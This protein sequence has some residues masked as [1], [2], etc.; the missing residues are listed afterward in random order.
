MPDKISVLVGGPAGTGIMTTGPTLSRAFSRGGLHVYVNIEYPSLIRGGHNS[1]QIC[2]GTSPVHSHFEYIDFLLA[3][4]SLT[5]EEH[6]EELVPGANIVCDAK[7]CRTEEITRGYDVNI[8]SMPIDEIAVESGG[9]EVMRNMVALGATVALIGYNFDCLVDAI[10]YTFRARPKIADQNVITAKAGY[11]YINEHH[12]NYIKP[13]IQSIGGPKRIS[14]SGNEAIA[15]GAIKAGMKWYSAYPMTPSTSVLHYLMSHERAFDLVIKQPEDEI[16][17]IMMAIG[18]AF[19]GVR[20]G[21]GTSGGGFCL[22]TEGLGLAGMIEV[23]LVIVEAQRG[24]PST[25]LPTRQE[26]A[27][28]GFLVTASQGEFPRIIIA[29]GDVDECFYETFNAFNLA[30]RYQVPVFVLTDKYLSENFQTTEPFKTEGLKIN[31]GQLLSEEEI[32]SITEFKRFAFTESGISPRSIPGQSKGIHR[33]TGNEH[34]ESGHISDDADNRK[35]M[36]EKRV[37]RKFKTIQKDIPGP[38]Q[39]GPETAPLTLVCW[40]ST[41][42]AAQEAIK[43]LQ[44]DGISVNALHFSYV[45]PIPVETVQK[46]IQGTQ[47]TLLLEQNGTGQ[48]GKLIRQETGIM[49]DYTLLKYNGRPFLPNEIAKKVKEVL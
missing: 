45:W 16:S 26:Q 21:T 24:G 30:D 14:L 37:I 47:K 49:F 13:L 48:F 20:A 11:D 8:I 18:A 3:F 35:N 46:T 17:A 33:V 36:V 29:P 5:V 22:M 28:L 34:L 41:K 19:T 9:L 32:E 10:R 6:L 39:Y 15:L 25:G 44:A 27:D 23:P 4:D 12:S 7:K 2:A 31:R 38:K 1:A 43:Y 42:G 40:G